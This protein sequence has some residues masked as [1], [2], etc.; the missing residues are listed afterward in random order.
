MKQDFLSELLNSPQ[1]SRV[2]RAIVFNENELFTAER[3]GKRAGVPAK[4]AARELESFEKWGLVKRT[5]LVGL[6]PAV[7]GA[8][9]RKHARAEKGYMFD[10]LFKHARVLSLFVREISPLRYDQILDALKKSGKL[11]TVILSGSF[12]GDMTRPA[13]ILVA[14]DQLNEA[15][16]EGAVRSLEP[17]FGRELRYAGFSTPEFRYRLT[18]Q[19]R[20]IRD[21]LDY[22]HLILLDRAVLP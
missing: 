10:Q 18:V 5:M 6:K 11:S 13:D 17:L 8:G 15:R 16:L 12:M 1:R 14:A 4:V 7:K 2:L 22:P 19:D 20:L 9:K 3:L 21:T